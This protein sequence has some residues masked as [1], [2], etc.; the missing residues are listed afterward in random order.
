MPAPIPELAAK[1]AVTLYTLLKK[2]VNGISLKV[3]E[4][5][6]LDTEF[7]NYMEHH[8]QDVFGDSDG[9]VLQGMKNLETRPLNP[10]AFDHLH[11]TTKMELKWDADDTVAA[12]ASAD[13]LIKL[14]RDRDNDPKAPPLTNKDYLPWLTFE[15]RYRCALETRLPT[16]NA[17]PARRIGG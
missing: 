4:A 2:Q 10:Q 13:V 8:W 1:A 7:A 12:T 11:K 15:V 9:G 6:R 3:P 14:L 5:K 16:K 17:L